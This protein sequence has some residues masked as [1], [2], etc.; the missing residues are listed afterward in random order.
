MGWGD[1]GGDTSFVQVLVEERNLA[2]DG[3]FDLRE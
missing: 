2:V 3:A 1:G